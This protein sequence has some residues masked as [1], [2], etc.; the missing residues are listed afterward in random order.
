MKS[1]VLAIFLVKRQAA[2]CQIVPLR[3]F[4]ENTAKKKPYV[5]WQ[6][7]QERQFTPKPFMHGVIQTV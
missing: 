2:A 6:S 5:S 4:R 7:D 1:S 3:F